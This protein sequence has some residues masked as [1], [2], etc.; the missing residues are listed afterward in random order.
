MGTMDSSSPFNKNLIWS[1]LAHCL[2]LASV[3]LF[4][5]FSQLEPPQETPVWINLDSFQPAEPPRGTME[6]LPLPPPPAPENVQQEVPNQPEPIPEDPVPSPEPEPEPEPQPQPE[7]VVEKPIVKK[8]DPVK[9]EKKAPTPKKPVKP[10]VEK[11]KITPPVKPV[12][13]I[14]KPKA[15][16]V[17]INKRE[18]TRNSLTKTS[19][20]PQPQQSEFNPN[21]F[22]ERLR[23][24]LNSGLITAKGISTGGGSPGQPNDFSAY[25]N[26][27]FQAMYGAWHPPLGLSDGLT[28]KV[29]IRVERDGTIS[30]VSLAQPSGNKP[31]DDSAIAAAKSVKKLNPLPDELGK[32]FAEITVHFKIQR[33]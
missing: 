23:G 15:P 5:G 30:K 25:F 11:P 29:L 2:I 20:K 8:P 9:L 21:A 12:Q 27:V 18:V 14:D 6:A 4:L 28:S 1:G 13:K 22:A 19:A 31:M 7:A 24:K 17:K 32:E 3:A 26:H 33:Q 10:P 16:A